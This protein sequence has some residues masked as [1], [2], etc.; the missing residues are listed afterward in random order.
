M[1]GTGE[2]IRK[3]KRELAKNEAL[4]KA[5]DEAVQILPE[6]AVRVGNSLQAMGNLFR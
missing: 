3:K 4:T 5:G 6:D 2:R 1:I